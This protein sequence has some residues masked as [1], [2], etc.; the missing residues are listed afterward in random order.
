MVFLCINRWA[1]VSGSRSFGSSEFAVR[2]VSLR[3]RS[4]SVRS[5][6][7]TT[8]VKQIQRHPLIQRIFRTSRARSSRFATS[9]LS[10]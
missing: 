6:H 8:S 3:I 4:I 1:G 7:R 10:R 2:A 5:V 9:R